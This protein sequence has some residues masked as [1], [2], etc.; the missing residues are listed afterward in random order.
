MPP[1]GRCQYFAIATP[2]PPTS[3][4]D[5]PPPVIFPSADSPS[6][7]DVSDFDGAEDHAIAQ[8]AQGRHEAQS[9]DDSWVD[10]IDGADRQRAEAE[11]GNTAYAWL[12][13]LT[14]LYADTSLGEFAT[15]VGMPTWRYLN[16][17][18]ARSFGAQ[19]APMAR[20]LVAGIAAAEVAFLTAP[21]LLLR[22]PTLFI[23]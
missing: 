3:F 22:A 8:E 10:G 5:G 12:E 1:D 4:F 20:D 11:L 23:Y 9:S 15:S 17:A 7:M 16:A 14:D 18:A 13:P 21:W 6:A 2:E 19:V